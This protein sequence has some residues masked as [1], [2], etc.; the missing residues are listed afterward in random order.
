MTSPN[1]ATRAPVTLS[2]PLLLVARL[3]ALG[4]R[5]G[6]SRS[7]L[8]EKLLISGARAA[9][10]SALEEELEAYYGSI[11]PGESAEDESLAQAFALAGRTV[12]IDE[13]RPRAALP[14]RRRAV[15]ERP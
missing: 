1:R 2:L 4:K 5:A 3:D 11:R 8:F 10:R 14:R 9:K 6:L 12:A 15:G 7:R 13:T